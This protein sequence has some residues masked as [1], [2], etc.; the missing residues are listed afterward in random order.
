M[1]A[2]LAVARW[3]LALLVR[4]LRFAPPLLGELAL[5]LVLFAT[6][7]QAPKSAV[8]VSAVAIFALAVWCGLAAAGALAGSGRDVTVVSAGRGATLAGEL[9]ADGVAVVIGS[10]LVLL[11][12]L[13]VVKPAMGPLP[14]LIGFAGV[15]AAGLAGIAVAELINALRLDV[16]AR[17]VLGLG[18]VCLTLAR[19]ALADGSPVARA[20]AVV[21]PPV[22]SNVKVL[23]D[24]FPDVVGG[25][26][27]VAVGC[28]AW[29]AVVVGATWLIGGRR[30]AR[31]PSTARG[32]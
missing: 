28:L 17:F 9:V 32:G 7:P 13:P 14:W 5:V 4:S 30:I 18:L 15:V 19:P 16:A 27:L 1:S 11:G 29:A 2:A 10:G 23:D 8:A 12:S 6:G 31:V 26:L 3:R 24:G 22:L 25:A 20:V 21:L